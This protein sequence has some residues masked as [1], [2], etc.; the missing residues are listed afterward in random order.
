MMH[1]EA[2][3]YNTYTLIDRMKY[4]KIDMKKKNNEKN[5]NCKLKSTMHMDVPLQTKVI[6]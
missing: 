1:L 6:G 2:E 4:I 3:T 5:N